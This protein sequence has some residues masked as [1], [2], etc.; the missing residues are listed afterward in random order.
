MRII[1]LVITKKK[2]YKAIFKKITMNLYCVSYL[3][4]RKLKYLH[5]ISGQTL[6]PSEKKE[7]RNKNVDSQCKW[8]TLF[9]GPIEVAFFLVLRV[10]WYKSIVS[11][12]IFACTEFDVDTI[13]LILDSLH[14]HQPFLFRSHWRARARIHMYNIYVYLNVI[15]QRK[16]ETRIRCFVPKKENLTSPVGTQT[17]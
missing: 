13:V 15:I 5:T 16:S 2:Q 1:F 11:F 7:K 8:P 14:C 12:L 17:R 9:I 10:L 4:T 6:I 3:F